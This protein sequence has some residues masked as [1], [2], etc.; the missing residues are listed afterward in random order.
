MLEVCGLRLRI[1]AT[2]ILRGVD[3]AV[4]PGER[5]ALIGPNGAG[6]SS[7]FHLISGRT[8]PSGGEVWLRGQRIDRW[9]PHRIYRA[10]L[11]RSFQIT[12]LFPQLTVWDNLR[13]ATLWQQ[14]QGYSCWRWLDSLRG[15]SDRAEELLH[16]LGL[17]ARRD[18]L[19]QH[20]S[21]AEQRALDMG[22]AL[23]GGAEVLL[24]DEPTAG[25]NQAE[26]RQTVAL[27]RELTEGKTLLMVEHD[28]GVVFDLA[29]RIAVLVQGELI[30]LGTPQD[31]RQDP[32]VREA[33]LGHAWDGAGQDTWARSDECCN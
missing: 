31:I 7:L 6:K 29:D 12:Q 23:A 15:V 30:A 11:A 16:R 27:V 22:L 26:T 10:G 13:C 19:A 5:L 18:V 8:R 20:L 17:A 24:L 14:G 9:P 21:Y 1:G 25:M 28:M 2:D 4:Q 33:Y 32:R 3:L